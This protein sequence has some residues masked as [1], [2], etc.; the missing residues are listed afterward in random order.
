MSIFGDGTQTRAF[1]YIDDVAPVIASVIDH[2]DA[3]NE[4]YNVGSDKWYDVNALARM[5][6][7]AFGVK[8]EVRHFPARNEVKDAYST[9]EKI[10]RR[11][12]CE[13]RVELPEGVRRMVAWAKGHGPRHSKPFADIEIMKNLPSAWRPS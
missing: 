3:F 4:V 1:S 13:A 11:L 2:P 7:D 10:R 9:H 5:V 12:G 6:A 8:P